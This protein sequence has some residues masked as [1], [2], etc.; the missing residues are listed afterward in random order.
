M[1]GR[2]QLKDFR[3]TGHPYEIAQI[4]LDA[5]H[6]EDRKAKISENGHHISAKILNEEIHIDVKERNPDGAQTFF[7]TVPVDEGR[8]KAEKILRTL[9]EIAQKKEKFVPPIIKSSW[10]AYQLKTPFRG[11][12]F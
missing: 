1:E 5:I 3:D 12:F 11:L 2:I 7:Y 8:S 4:I 6:S 9:K 10:Q